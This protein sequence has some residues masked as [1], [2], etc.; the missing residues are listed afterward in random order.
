MNINTI[1]KDQDLITKFLN[2][3]LTNEEVLL[4]KARYGSD[5]EFTSEVN[6]HS[7]IYLAFKAAAEIEQ[8]K[9]VEKPGELKGPSVIPAKHY[10]YFLPEN[11]WVMR[12]AAVVVPLIAFTVGLSLRQKPA[13]PGDELYA[14]FYENSQPKEESRSFAPDQQAS[15]Q[16]LQKDIDAAIMESM[17]ALSSGA[18]IHAFGLYCMAQQRFNEAVI[19]FKSL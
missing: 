16:F 4:F 5:T 17:N 11:K 8:E 15:F 9:K 6:A 3:E 2:N 10:P 7:E 13:L 1:E 14:R 12:I 18:D 19:A